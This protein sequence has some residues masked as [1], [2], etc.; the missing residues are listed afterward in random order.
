MVAS[1]PD[2]VGYGGKTMRQYMLN[3]WLVAAM[4]ALVC[5]L[6]LTAY[7]EVREAPPRIACVHGSPDV[8]KPAA[9]ITVGAATCQGMAQR[10]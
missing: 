2:L 5:L 3:G 4:L 9:K 7:A 6:G 8:G 10:A 1:T